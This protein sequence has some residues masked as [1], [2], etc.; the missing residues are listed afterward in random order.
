M[1]VA[2]MHRRFEP[3]KQQMLKKP[4]VDPIPQGYHTVTPYLVAED[5][6]ALLEFAKQA[7]AAEEKFRGIGGSRRAAR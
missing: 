5:G 6:P 4:A 1:S 2:E 3:I 7:F